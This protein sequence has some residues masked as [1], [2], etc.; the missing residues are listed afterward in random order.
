MGRLRMDP[1]RRAADL[2]A[3]TAYFNPVGYRRRLTNY[4]EFRRRLAAPLVT[5]ELA[6]SRAFEL[7]PDDADILVRIKDGD[8]LWQKE[9]LL[10]IAWQHLP[11]GCRK[12]AWLDADVFFA[13]DDWVDAAAAQLDSVPLIMLFSRVGEL[14]PDTPLEGSPPL[15]TCEVGHSIAHRWPTGAPPAGSL[16][17]DLRAARTHSGLAWASRREIVDDLGLYDAC[18]V[19]SGNRA[20]ACAALGAFD[21]AVGYLC[22]NPRWAA[23]YLAW[24]RRFHERVQGRVACLEMTAFHLWHGDLARRRY[25]ER[26]HD[27]SR[28]DFDPTSDI[29]AA[30]GGAWLWTSDKPAMHEFV[31]SYFEARREDG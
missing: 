1:G 28:Y 20:I 19:G 5:V 31:R 12:V 21:D 14:G 26:H 24:G 23:H 3:I 25:A 30:D 16:R 2:W 11:P 9:R 8:V 6:T 22:M 18:V 15:A 17:S 29:G 7:G 13:S 4:R 10:N 27:F